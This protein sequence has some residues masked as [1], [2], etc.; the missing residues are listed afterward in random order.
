MHPFDKAKLYTS[1]LVYEA[2]NNESDEFSR[3]VMTSVS[4]FMRLDWGDTMAEDIAIN[5]DAL[6]YKDRVL[7]V[8]ETIKGRVF[9]TAESE[10]GVDY[11]TLVIMFP[12]EY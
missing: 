11:T 8:Y 9:I 5:I 6:K 1:K 7:A 4:R 3:E 12:E 10:D 2:M